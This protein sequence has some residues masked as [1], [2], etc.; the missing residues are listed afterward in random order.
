MEIFKGESMR[1]G[2]IYLFPFPG[3]T[4]KNGFHI[5]AHRSEYGIHLKV[6]KPYK[7]QS[8]PISYEKLQKIIEK[9]RPELLRKL[10]R[11]PKKGLN[12]YLVIPYVNPAGFTYSNRN[13]KT[14]MALTDAVLSGYELKLMQDTH[15]IPRDILN[16]PC[17]TDKSLVFAFTPETLEITRYVPLD[18]TSLEKVA[19]LSENLD[20]D[21]MNKMG[22][23]FFTYSFGDFKELLEG[24]EEIIDV[25]LPFLENLNESGGQLF[26][27]EALESLFGSIASRQS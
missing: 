26:S 20:F 1:A 16:L 21:L 14:H 12:Y 18:K 6:T 11:L 25:V 4:A 5:S 2:D 19:D 10:S 17:T 7:I 8:N 3:A 9:N 22:G 27:S 15:F 23:A 13:G 24:F